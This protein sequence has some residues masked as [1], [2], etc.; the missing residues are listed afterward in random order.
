MENLRD[1]RIRKFNDE[2]DGTGMIISV[3]RETTI[4]N[5]CNIS[6]DLKKYNPNSIFVIERIQENNK[7]D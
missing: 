5:I 3:I 2:N 1:Y 7:Q 6:N 4:E